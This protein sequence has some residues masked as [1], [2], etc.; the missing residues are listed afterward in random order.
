M[1]AGAAADG[2]VV[3]G[4]GRIVAEP[5]VGTGGTAEAHSRNLA[6]RA[7]DSRQNGRNSITGSRAAHTCAAPKWSLSTCSSYRSTCVARL[8]LV[9][10]VR[11]ASYGRA[12]GGS[13]ANVIYARNWAIELFARTGSIDLVDC[14]GSIMN[15]RVH[16]GRA[17]ARLCTGLHAAGVHRFT[18]FREFN[19]G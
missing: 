9:S 8:Q 4:Y 16:V 6:P 11:T 2:G 13:H 1:G 3:K 5:K 12:R 18:C 7:A 14:G 15:M 10:Y 17:G 19:S